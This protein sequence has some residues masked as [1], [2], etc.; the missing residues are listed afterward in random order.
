M[1]LEAAKLKRL[2]R[3]LKKDR[4]R[5]ARQ[6]PSASEADSLSNK[7]RT[8]F[9]RNSTPYFKPLTGTSLKVPVLDA[10]KELALASSC[11]LRLVGIQD[12][13]ATFS[14]AADCLQLALVVAI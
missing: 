9:L 12:T 3:F 8:R 7:R 1:P 2:T 11:L 5:Q 10:Q 6:K 13:A 4:L 14:S